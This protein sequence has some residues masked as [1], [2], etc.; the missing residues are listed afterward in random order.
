MVTVK[1]KGRAEATANPTHEKYIKVR[2]QMQAET[3][4]RDV[5]DYIY[6]YKSITSYEAFLHLSNTRLSVSVF[7]L[8][9]VYGLPVVTH[10]TEHRGKRFGVYSID[11]DAVDA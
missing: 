10:M 1:K 11:W 2:K 9:H 6:R 3:N 7:Q 4:V 5:L 8:R